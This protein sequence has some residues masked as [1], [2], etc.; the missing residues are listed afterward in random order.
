MENETLQTVARYNYLKMFPAATGMS[1]SS[2]GMFASMFFFPFFPFTAILYLIIMKRVLIC[3]DYLAEQTGWLDALFAL[4][5]FQGI[6]D[7]FMDSLNPIELGL[8]TALC[9]EAC[10]QKKQRDITKGE[11]VLAKTY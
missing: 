10:V 6:F 7:S 5:L 8:V 11:N 4:I 9:I 1:G 2:P 3:F